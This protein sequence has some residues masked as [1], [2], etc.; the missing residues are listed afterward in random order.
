M[1]HLD[2]LYVQP[3]VRSEGIGA[4]L[5]QYAMAMAQNL[6]ADRLEWQTPMRNERAITFCVRAGACKQAKTRFSVMI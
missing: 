6:G 3:Q 2:Y 1:A 5:L 4:S